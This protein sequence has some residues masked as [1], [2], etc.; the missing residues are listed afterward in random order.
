VGFSQ[1][2]IVH[3]QQAVTMVQAVQGRV[4]APV[5]QLATGIELNQIKEIGQLQ[6][7]LALWN[8]PLVPSGPPMTWMDDGHK[9]HGRPASGAMPG[10]AS[11]QEMNSLGKAGNADVRFL[12]LMIRH[13]EGGLLMTAAAA[14]K[15]KHPQVRALATTMASEQRKETATMLGLLAALGQRPLASPALGQGA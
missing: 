11:V 3:H 4:S 12:K 8:A 2:M 10:M 9:G 1:D 14:G 13:H 7:W 15:A 6:G 5:A